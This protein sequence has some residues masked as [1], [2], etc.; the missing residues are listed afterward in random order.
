MNV[1]WH[2]FDHGRLWSKLRILRQCSTMYTIVMDT[3]TTFN[4][5]QL[6]SYIEMEGTAN[7]N[8]LKPINQDL[9][10][11][12]AFPWQHFFPQAFSQR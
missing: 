2:K 6:W 10:N 5:G 7:N 11:F 12:V 8:I 9:P 3:M 1:K 4:N